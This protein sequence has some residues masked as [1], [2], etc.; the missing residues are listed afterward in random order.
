VPSPDD[1]LPPG[2][3]DLSRLK[4][5]PTV[6]GDEAVDAM[7]NAAQ[8]AGL[9]CTSCGSFL[10]GPATEYV[11]IR[12]EGTRCVTSKA[13]ICSGDDPECV[14][15]REHLEGSASASR[16]CGG[17]TRLTKGNPEPGTNGNPS[18]N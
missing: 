9:I 4:Q 14:A 11:T 16:P 15:A 17:W 12:L 13:F 7:N 18:L 8:M 5:Q 6:L 1:E 10:N 3:L 2:A